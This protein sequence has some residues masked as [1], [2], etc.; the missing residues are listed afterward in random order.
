M[1]KPAP[2]GPHQRVYVGPVWGFGVL[3]VL[4]ERVSGLGLICSI[5]VM[6]TI[7]SGLV[8]GTAWPRRER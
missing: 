8:V 5:C 4:W 3:W 2:W 6:K 1:A 7:S